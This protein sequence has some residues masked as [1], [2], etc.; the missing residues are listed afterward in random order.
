MMKILKIL[1]VVG[2][3]LA[4]W[5]LMMVGLLSMVVI[6]TIMIW[7]VLELLGRFW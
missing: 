5:G 1:W 4:F 7:C 2:S 3:E 6:A